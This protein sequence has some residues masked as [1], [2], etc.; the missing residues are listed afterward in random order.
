VAAILTIK[1]A[2]ID[3][4]TDAACYSILESNNIEFV[5]FANEASKVRNPILSFF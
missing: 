5:A 3:F 2:Y 4:L 1:L